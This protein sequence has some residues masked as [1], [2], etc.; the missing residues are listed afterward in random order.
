MCIKNE[1]TS[2][3][4]FNVQK[5]MYRIHKVTY[6]KFKKVNHFCNF[7]FF[8]KSNEKSRSFYQ[9]LISFIKFK[10]RD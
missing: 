4:L 7:K 10:L 6:G 2:L 8:L 9:R 5:Q 1:L 3:K